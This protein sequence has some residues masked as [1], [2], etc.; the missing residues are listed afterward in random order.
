[1]VSPHILEFVQK[2]LS[3]GQK[4]EEIKAHLLQ[5]GINEAV[6]QEALQTSISP[7]RHDLFHEGNENKEAII[8]TKD[9]PQPTQIQITPPAQDGRIKVLR[10]EPKDLVSAHQVSDTLAKSEDVAPGQ[11][12]EESKELAKGFWDNIILAAMVFVFL[13]I[14]IFAAYFIIIRLK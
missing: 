5:M 3:Q 12:F 13:L 14:V 10:E 11:D 6:A 9:Q 1:M 8:I 7:I 4:P 2:Q